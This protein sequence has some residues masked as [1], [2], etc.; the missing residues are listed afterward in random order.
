MRWVHPLLVVEPRLLLD[1]QWEG[2]SATRIG[3]DNLQP[4]F[5]LCGGS[6]VQGQGGGAL[7]WSVVV[8]WVCRLWDFPSGSGQGQPHLCSAWDHPAGD[9]EQSEMSATFAGIGHS[10]VK[11]NCESTLAAASDGP[12]AHWDQL[13]LVWEDLGSCEASASHSYGQAAWWVCKL[14][15]AEYLGIFKAD[16]TVLARLMESQIWH[17]FVSSVWGGFRKGSMVFSYL[18]VWEKAI[19]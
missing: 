13:L 10:Q 5:T 14:G 3:C 4:N 17:Q 2:F 18:S 1:N 12:G 15:G 6:A 19:P 7:T 8:H 11:P 16:Q 9:I